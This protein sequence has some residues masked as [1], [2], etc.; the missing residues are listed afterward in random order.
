MIDT[1]VYMNSLRLTRACSLLTYT[2]YRLFSVR[3]S[4]SGYRSPLRGVPGSDT[5]ARSPFHNIE[6]LI[7]RLRNDKPFTYSSELD[8]SSRTMVHLTLMNWLVWCMETSETHREVA[9]VFPCTFQRQVSIRWV[10]HP[11]QQCSE[12]QGDHLGL[13]K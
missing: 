13:Q 4:S 8:S 2:C 9:V 6:A 12:L 7:G 5:Q 10:I 3:S 1:T 11:S